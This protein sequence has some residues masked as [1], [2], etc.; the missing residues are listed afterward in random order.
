MKRSEVLEDL[1]PFHMSI[2][3]YFGIVVTGYLFFSNKLAPIFD[4]FPMR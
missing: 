2:S 1:F 4:D 3:F